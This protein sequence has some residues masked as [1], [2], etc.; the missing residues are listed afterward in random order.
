MLKIDRRFSGGHFHK[1]R[2]IKRCSLI[3]SAIGKGIA[4]AVKLNVLT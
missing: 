4:I 2:T 1:I 3:S